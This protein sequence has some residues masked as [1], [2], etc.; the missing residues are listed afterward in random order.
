MAFW[1]TVWIANSMFS[2]W[3]NQSSQ[4]QTHVASTQSRW[5]AFPRIFHL[6]FYREKWQFPPQVKHTLR[7]LYSIRQVDCSW[8]IASFVLAPCIAGCGG[9]LVSYASCIIPNRLFPSVIFETKYT[10]PSHSQYPVE[11]NF[12][13]KL[14]IQLHKTTP[15]LSTSG[16][17]SF[18]GSVLPPLLSTFLM[19]GGGLRHTF[20]CF[21]IIFPSVGSFE[22]SG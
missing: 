19:T 18:L 3:I 21:T 17:K 6:V 14:L 12:L 8:E 5:A 15:S 10:G 11:Q 2:G 4:N 9:C 1:L 22:A 20:C 16:D 7:V 13:Q